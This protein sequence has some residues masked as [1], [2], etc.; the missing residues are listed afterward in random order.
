MT[1]PARCPRC[2]SPD[3]ARHPAMQHGG[4]VQI[5]RHPWHGLPALVMTAATAWPKWPFKESPGEFT[6]RLGT[7]M[8]N[9][10]SLLGAV[11]NV[12][13]EHPPEIPALEAE[14]A[15]HAE[16]RARAEKA[17]ARALSWQ[18]EIMRAT[19]GGSEFCDPVAT[20][21]YLVAQR[22]ELHEANVAR[23]RAERR[24]EKAEAER[25]TV[26]RREAATIHRYDAKLDAL[27]AQLTTAREALRPFPMQNGPHVPRTAAEIVYAAYA[28][29]YGTCQTLDRLGVR[30]G[31]SW[32][33]VEV[34]FAELRKKHPDKHRE[35]MTR[36]RTT[37][38]ETAG[39]PD[40][41]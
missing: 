37:L 24:A 27:E 34:I 6:E 29:M 2:D 32:K 21:E 38:L 35:I 19:P 5:C 23:V 25:D 9:E 12:L 33:E 18:R 22:N 31:F 1:E 40:P 10:I 15:T 39:E 16:T 7:A 14:R 30:G 17:E 8:A 41:A 20:A 3:P 4:E 13:I 11:R 26:C 28:H 36:A